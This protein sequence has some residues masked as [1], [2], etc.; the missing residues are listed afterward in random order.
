MYDDPD[1]FDALLP[2]SGEQRSFYVALAQRQA[3][4]V[5]ELACGSGQLLVP[6][7]GTG[8]ACVG[9]DSSP[10]MLDGARRRASAAGAHVDLIDG[11]MR[12]FDLGRR[13]SL[14][15]VARNSLL[16]LSELE[17]FA[18]L[19]QAVGRHLEPD[20]VLA[21][22]I[23]NPSIPALARPT[24]ERFDVMRVLATPYGELTVEA[25]NDYDPASQ[26]NRATWFI[27]SATQRDAWTSQLHMRSIFPQELLSLLAANGFRLIR[28]DGDYAGSA[29]TG[30]S[31]RQV[32]QCRPI[33]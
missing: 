20:G 15:L 26:V 12:D 6:V 4:S 9:L 22:D 1:L 21:F 19:F 13:F 23:Y 25:T 17:D 29:F 30:T 10:Q 3:G 33:A 27:S 2:A 7:A 16:H 32:C 11:D 28:R 31:P 18:R 14:V 8:L 24:G 5:L